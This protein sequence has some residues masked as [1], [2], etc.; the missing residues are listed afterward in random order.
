MWLPIG[1]CPGI[2][3]MESMI[4]HV[5]RSLNMDVETVKK[6]NLYQKGQVREREI[7]GLGFHLSREGPKLELLRFQ[8]EHNQFR[9]GV[10]LWLGR[11]ILHPSRYNLDVDRYIERE[12]L[13]RV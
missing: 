5:A 4:D 3:I 13:K 12:N 10:R 9:E 8:W 2:F 7:D 11:P 1:T 6:A